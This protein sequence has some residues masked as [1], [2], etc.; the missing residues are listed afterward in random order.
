VDL[1]FRLRLKVFFN[2]ELHQLRVGLGIGPC[3]ALAGGIAAIS[4][5]FG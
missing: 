4:Y 3:G 1:L 5:F 2:Y